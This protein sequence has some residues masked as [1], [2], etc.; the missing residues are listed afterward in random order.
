MIAELRLRGLGVIDEAT[1]SFAPGLTVLTGETGAGKTM[2]LTGLALVMGR[3]AD[4]GVVRSGAS[5]VDVDSTWAIE[6]DPS[7]SDLLDEAGVAI[8]EDGDRAQLILS[9]SVAAEGRSRAYAG[10]RSVPAA[11]LTAITDR[12][13]AVHGQS[14]QL[15]LRESAHQLAL[16]DRFAGP[17][18]TL[19][20]SNFR[21]LY[22]RW[23][24][25]ERELRDLIAQRTERER[26]AELLRHGIA[27]IETANPQPGEDE[28]LK[29]QAGVLAHAADL[30]AHAHEAQGLIAG[31]ESG[32]AGAAD[33]IAQ[34]LKTLERAT[35]L[36]P[37]LGALGTRLDEIATSLR[38]VASD[39]GRYAAGIEVD[40]P[41]QAR[42][43]ERRHLL[44]GLKRRYG[45]ALDDVLAWWQSAQDQVAATDGTQARI[46]E[47]TEGAEDRRRALVTAAATLTRARADAAEE[48]AARV[49]AELHDLAM[50]DAE[51]VVEV[52]STAAPEDFTA[53]GADRVT[54]LLRPHA[55]SEPRPLGKGA[56]GGELSRVMLAIEVA[57][58]GTT[59][60]PTYV[61]DEVDAGIGGRV[62][63]EVGR[64]LA[65]LARGAQVIVVT[66]LPQVA[67]FADRHVVVSK[68]T[69][70]AVTTASVN[71]VVGDER[72]AEIVRMLAGL[73]GSASGAEHAAEL[74][75][76]AAQEQA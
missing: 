2:V 26:E 6:P 62:A 63:V 10:G 61:F 20:H 67:A 49:T 36:D 42:V 28:A 18:V 30:I 5:S 12:L 44:A 65:R 68:G 51:V 75:A 25:A 8:E 33:L 55:G 17:D 69:D 50:A 3:K 52:Q 53:D 38:E 34:A 1:I 76:L 27:E 56:S 73:E 60:V 23:R 7:L 74:L 64:R 54:M 66:H 11:T 59:G 4:G 16:L 31:D 58:A 47:L 9:R 35:G 14:D 70:G 29:L 13:I 15:L 40:P 71:E 45:P 43:E 41:E 24:S 39:V 48:F 72:V 37:S 46:E 19:L 57:L 32:S 22:D 21:V